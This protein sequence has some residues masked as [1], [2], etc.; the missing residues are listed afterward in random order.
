MSNRSKKPPLRSLKA[1]KSSKPSSLLKSMSSTSIASNKTAGSKSKLSK[2]K[3]KSIPIKSAAA[4]LLSPEKLQESPERTR[5]SLQ[6]KQSKKIS[7]QDRSKK[8]NKKT[9]NDNTASNDKESNSKAKN[10]KD[11]NR[12]KNTTTTT[13]NT[14]DL[15]KQDN[16]N[17]PLDN[18]NNQTKTSKTSNKNANKRKKL[19]K[20]TPTST[21]TST[22]TPTPTPTPTPLVQ[23]TVEF[24]ERMCLTAEEKISG[25]YFERQTINARK[26]QRDDF[27]LRMQN[28]RNSLKRATRKKRK[29]LRAK[30]K[31]IKATQELV[32]HM[33]DQSNGDLIDSVYTSPRS[34]NNN[35][36]RK[37]LNYMSPREGDMSMMML[38]GGRK[39]R[40][41]SRQRDSKIESN[42]FQNTNKNDADNGG[43]SLVSINKKKERTKSHIR[44]SLGSLGRSKNSILEEK[45]SEIGEDFDELL[46]SPAKQRQLNMLKREKR[47]LIERQ[48]Y[49]VEYMAMTPEEKKTRLLWKKDHD[50]KQRQKEIAA[51]KLQNPV[52]IEPATIEPEP[53]LSHVGK[54]VWDYSGV[55]RLPNTTARL[56]DTDSDDDS[57]ED[58]DDEDSSLGSTEASTV[59]GYQKPERKNDPDLLRNIFPRPGAV[60][61]RTWAK[62]GMRFH[63]LP[64]EQQ[65]RA[66]KREKQLYLLDMAD[67]TLAK[68]EA[69]IQ[70][71]ENYRESSG[72][73]QVKIAAAAMQ[74]VLDHLIGLKLSATNMTDEQIAD[75]S[76]EYCGKLHVAKSQSRKSSKSTEEKETN[77][78]AT[79]ATEISIETNVDVNELLDE[80][81]MVV[82]E[83]LADDIH[84]I[85][86][87]LLH[88][89]LELIKFKMDGK[90]I[91]SA[92][93]RR[94]IGLA[95]LTATF[96]LER[97]DLEQHIDKMQKEAKNLELEIKQED[98][99]DAVRMKEIKK[100]NNTPYLSGKKEH[101]PKPIPCWVCKEHLKFTGP[102]GHMFTFCTGCG[103]FNQNPKAKPI[104]TKK[105]LKDPR[106]R[107]Q[108][109]ELVKGVNDVIHAIGKATVSGKK[110]KRSIYAD[111]DRLQRKAAI[112]INYNLG[113]GQYTKG[114]LK[115]ERKIGKFNFAASIARPEVLER[116]LKKQ[117]RERDA[118]DAGIRKKEEAK[119]KSIRPITSDSDQTT[120]S[121]I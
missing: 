31:E 67:K 49:F 83:G 9:K 115:N 35:S 22:S 106:I 80:F 118:R 60:D 76:G 56:E 27:K 26:R 102:Q 23:A 50:K 46:G 45:N 107:R 53:W 86:F 61:R 43:M 88:E 109:D 17:T 73:E 12:H 47:K 89:N 21:S 68:I 91:Q 98:M 7:K 69:S 100:K 18:K 37:N 99:L 24:V 111:F 44:R 15:T 52:P 113:P 5:P 97:Q 39:K 25:K 28:I 19:N 110:V 40:P 74:N 8:S 75:A 71:L 96:A 93:G 70:E 3:K 78:L 36:N 16:K 10:K 54:R 6:K 108:R 81:A 90:G 104:V 103:S 33:N 13:T 95:N 72:I 55:P 38:S 20:T 62:Y 48:P 114:L 58:S 57:E 1:L 82:T 59:D 30:I 65:S 64:K 79:T 112:P 42:F 120:T 119:L 51:E 105:A 101:R 84:S 77:V 121:S 116:I 29:F 117:K 2:L 94:H 34:P 11:K 41:A 32:L 63:R 4:A 85:N 14:Q 66:I 92:M 87:E